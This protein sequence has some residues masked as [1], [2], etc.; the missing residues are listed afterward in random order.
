MASHCAPLVRAHG[1]RLEGRLRKKLRR[2]AERREVALRLIAEHGLSQRR[3]SALAQIDPKRR[4]P[5]P[6]NADVRGRLRI[7]AG[8]RRRFG[9][10]R[11]GILLERE[12]IVMNKTNLL[13]LYTEEGLSVG[14]RR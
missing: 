6:D 10:R 1:E 12:G 5:V 2:P 7:P 4:N 13:R 8:E 3:A 9:Y 11:L 14:R